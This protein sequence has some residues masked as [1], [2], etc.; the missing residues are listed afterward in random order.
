[1]LSFTLCRLE[2]TR[3]DSNWLVNPFIWMNAL[4]VDAEPGE[5]GRYTAVTPPP[6]IG[7]NV[8]SLHRLKDV[9]NK[10]AHWRI[11]FALR[12]CGGSDLSSC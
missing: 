12:L 4:L 8:S 2:L 5:D 6:I 1:M 11:V 9:N 3:R 7:Q 10:G